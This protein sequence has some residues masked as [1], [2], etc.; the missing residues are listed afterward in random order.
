MELFELIDLGPVSIDT[1]LKKFEYLAK[2][3]HGGA[4]KVGYTS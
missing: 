4:V 1:A 2:G 3:F